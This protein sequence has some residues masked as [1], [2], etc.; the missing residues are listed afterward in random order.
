M[1]TDAELLQRYVHDRDEGAFSELVQRHFPVVY[2][3]A[4][5]R[6]HGRTE[7][8]EEATQQVFCDLA[9]KSASLMHHDSLI[10]WLYRS[11]RYAVIDALR[12]DL[13]RQRLVQRAAQEPE[14]PADERPPDWEELRPWLDAAMDDLRAG[15]REVVLMRYFY[16][17]SFREIGDRLGVSENTARMRTERGLERLRGLLARRGVRSSAAALAIALGHE[18]CA[19]GPA[20]LSATVTQAALA[21]GPAQGA[22]A[23]LMT[24]LMAKYTIPVLS[25]LVA[26]GVTAVVWTASTERVSAEELA[27]LRAERDQLQQAGVA[28]APSSTSTGAVAAAKPMSAPAV[29]PV[30]SNATL[31][32]ATNGPAAA[33][34]THA[35]EVTARGHSN[36]GTA[37]PMDAAMTFAWACDIADPVELARLITFDAD[38]RAAALEVMVAMPDEIRAQYTT[39]ESLYGMLMAASCMEAPPPG[40]D[41]MRQFMDMVELTPDRYA[42]RQKGNDRNVHEYQRTDAGWKYILPVAGV[43][44]LPGILKSD[45]LARLSARASTPAPAAAATP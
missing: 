17:H 15:D 16:D 36:H 8:A 29:S 26:A 42:S 44:G 11:V 19:S 35:P 27:V 41:M 3:A 20:G 7:L 2:A 39:P 12:A 38:G 4:V 25:G 31:A 30:A 13:R 34:A 24:F 10:G 40:A 32:V 33:S 9:R 45:T 6:G 37:T 18:A 28:A 5:R 14:E 23:A 22:G 43:R 1:C 21:V